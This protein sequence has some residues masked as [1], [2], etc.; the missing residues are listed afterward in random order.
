MT[1]VAHCAAELD[2]WFARVA[3]R[4]ARTDLRWRT[5]DYVRGLLGRAALKN[6]W[7]LGW[8]GGTASS[9]S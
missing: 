7:Q 1:E 2:S 9:G 5:R 6:G 8:A 3:G 4:F